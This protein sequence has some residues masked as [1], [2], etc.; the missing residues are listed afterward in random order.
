[1]LVV[2]EPEATALGAAMF[3]GVAAG[4]YPSFDA[5]FQNLDRKEYVVEPD[6]AA[7]EVYD[8]LRISVFAEIHD[9]LKP[10]NRGLAAFA[11]S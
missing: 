9:R 10:I 2:E 5:A 4:V 11:A 6:A 3:A 1:M 7:V 8:R